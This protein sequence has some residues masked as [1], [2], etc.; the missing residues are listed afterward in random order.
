[1]EPPT[2]EEMRRISDDYGL[3]L[4]QEELSALK[5][6][7][8]KEL[9]PSFQRLERM[10]SGVPPVRYPREGGWMPSREENPFGGW[11]WKCSI[12]GRS[13]GLLSG[14]KAAVKDN[15]SV[16]GVPMRNGS[17][18]MEGYIPRVDATIVS[19][20]L[21]AGGEITGKSMCEDLSLTGGSHTSK[22]WPVLN[23]FDATKMAGGSSGGSAALLAAGEVDVAIGGDQGGS[24]RLPSSWCGV[25]G[26]KPTWGL[27]PYTGIMS[28][29][30][31]IDHAGPMARSVR[32]L[33]LLLEAI[34]GRDG[35]D[36]RQDMAHVPA[37]LPAYSGLLK[38]TVEGLRVGLL[39]EGF[40]LNP[41]EPDV[42]EVV[43]ASASRFSQL[44]AAVEEVSVPLHASVSQM[45]DGMVWEGIWSTIRD[46]TGGHGWLGFYD[47]DL[48][49]YFGSAR[50]SGAADFSPQAKASIIV[51]H[52]LWEKY[53]S[54]FYGK[55]QNLRRAARAAYDEALAS[56]D[57]LLMPT[58][59]KRAQPFP[60]KGDILESLRAGEGM[61]PN[62]SQFD[63]TGH[64]ALN[65][66]CKEP[67][68][69]PLGMMLVA[70]H[71]AEPVILNAAYA[72]EQS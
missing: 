47:T 5:S 53:H 72:Y 4:T 32:D 46:D 41:M 24:I 15:V 54:V 29:D 12:R 2:L 20:I 39:K 23:P 69:L 36:P 49:E 37:T 30:L 26:L 63:F 70:K 3:G 16:A 58:A 59:S 28:L 25:F 64:P 6:Y 67:H 43:R 33:A 61:G 11:A 40:G 8:D 52:Y 65:V 56:Y 57:L 35:I 34:A 17:K 21:D 7:L 13:A 22:P 51:G 14:K 18:I 60:P 19:R 48:Q 27:V 1:M 31:S 10:E 55:A 68:G 38:P 44:G 62:D 45:F 42:D 50:R 71:F 66:P 9:V